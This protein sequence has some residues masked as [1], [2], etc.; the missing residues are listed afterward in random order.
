[1]RF[2]RSYSGRERPTDHFPAAWQIALT[3]PARMGENGGRS[4]KGFDKQDNQPV[5]TGKKKE[6]SPPR[7]GEKNRR[8]AL[9]K[10]TIFS[11]LG[12]SKCGGGRMRQYKERDFHRRDQLEEKRAQRGLSYYRLQKKKGRNRTRGGGG[13][14]MH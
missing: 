8:R 2:K 5:D 13:E 11:R 1:M 10:Q 4:P 9:R 3:K 7:R 6:R 12:Q 14:D